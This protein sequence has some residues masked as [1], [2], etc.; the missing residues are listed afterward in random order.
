MGGEE[1]MG[2]TGRGIDKQLIVCKELRLLS[3][4]P[5]SPA[6]PATPTRTPG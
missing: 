2:E 1:T 4:Y 3:I 6:T 5:T